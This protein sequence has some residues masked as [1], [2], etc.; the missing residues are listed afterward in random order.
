M[1]RFNNFRRR[2]L[3]WWGRRSKWGS[4]VDGEL[5]RRVTRRWGRLEGVRRR[6]LGMD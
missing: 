2:E 3:S 1:T 4:E 5:S 6:R